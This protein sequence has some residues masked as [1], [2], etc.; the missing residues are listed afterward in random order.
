[1]VIKKVKNFPHKISKCVENDNATST[2][3]NDI[4]CPR[5]STDISFVKNVAKFEIP[6]RL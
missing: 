3:N 6:Y 5:K 1:M 4:I 2:F